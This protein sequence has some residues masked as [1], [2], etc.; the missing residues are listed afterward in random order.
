MLTLTGL[1][2]HFPQGADSTAAVRRSL[3]RFADE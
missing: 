1:L 3:A 2:M